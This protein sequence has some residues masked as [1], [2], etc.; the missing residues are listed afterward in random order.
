MK[1]VDVKL[2]NVTFSL[3]VLLR[4]VEKVAIIWRFIMTFTSMPV[5]VIPSPAFCICTY[6]SIKLAAFCERLAWPFWCS[7]QD[8][9]GRRKKNAAV[10]T[11]RWTRACRRGCSRQTAWRST[12]DGTP[13]TRPRAWRRCWA[14]GRARWG[15]PGSRARAP[16]SPRTWTGRSTVAPWSAGHPRERWRFATG[17]GEM[18][19]S[20]GSSLHAPKTLEHW[21]FL[22][23]S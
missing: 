8:F 6:V 2:E 12:D 3:R 4:H 10:L 9:S 13:R 21:I 22:H 11:R 7:N 14:A 18:T 16:G 20:A 17:G 15:R 1:H 5:S 19:N 23:T